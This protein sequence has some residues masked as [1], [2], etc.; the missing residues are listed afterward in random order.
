MIDPVALLAKTRLF[1]S[2]GPELRAVIAASLRQASFSRGQT[3]F[4]QGDY[5][6]DLHVVVSG[7]LRLSV[8]SSEGK[9]LSFG[10]PGPGEVF[11]EIAAIDG[12][13]RTAQAVAI[14][15]VRTLALSRPALIDLIAAHAAIGNAVSQF[16][17]GRL[18]DTALQL[19]SIALRSIEAR[20]ARYLLMLVQRQ[21]GIDLP[22]A[23]SQTHPIT[24]EVSQTEF[25]TY[26][27][28]SRPK[29]NTVLA[30]LERKRAISRRGV[31]LLCN[32]AAL[33]LLAQ[34]G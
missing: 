26:L 16:L 25:S 28:A 32:G 31:H 30:L 5:G 9:E 4:E 21:H 15:A 8:L 33:T 24:F 29:V 17:C 1:G 3:L 20:V 10:H 2:L 19:E 12:G 22:A 23:Q 11:G 6:R 27:G 14:T 13:T 18:R 34:E 7:R